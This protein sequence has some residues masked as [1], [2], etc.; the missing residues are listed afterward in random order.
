MSF[1]TVFSDVAAF[2]WGVAG[3]HVLIAAPR[4]LKRIADALETRR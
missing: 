1:W 2:A 3:M 4:E